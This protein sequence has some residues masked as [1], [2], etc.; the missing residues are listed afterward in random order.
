ML[1]QREQWTKTCIPTTLGIYVFVQWNGVSLVAVF[2]SNMAV[3]KQRVLA[4]VFATVQLV[5]IIC[6]I[7]SYKDALSFTR[8][9]HA[10]I[11]GDN[12]GRH[13]RNT[14]LKPASSVVRTFA[15]LNG[16][17]VNISTS[18]KQTPDSV[19]HLTATDNSAD[20][21]ANYTLYKQVAN[22]SATTSTLPFARGY[23]YRLTNNTANSSVPQFASERDHHSSN[24]SANNSALQI[25]N[26]HSHHAQHVPDIVDSHWPRR[27]LYI[28]C[29][30][31]EFTYTNY[32]S[33]QSAVRSISP[34]A[35]MFA[36]EHYP[37]TQEDK[38]EYNTW[39]EDIIGSF[40][41]FMKYNISES[42]QLCQDDRSG[43]VA[44]IKHFLEKQDF[45]GCLYL[46]DQ[47]VL[48]EPFVLQDA[49]SILD[50]YDKHT[51]QGF[52]YI[53]TEPTAQ[54]QHGKC[55]L[56]KLSN[57]ELPDICFHLEPG[58][59]TGNPEGELDLRRATTLD[60]ES[61]MFNASP[62]ASQLR[63]ITYGS[64]D[65]PEQMPDSANPAPNIAHYAWIG[66]GQMNY[67]FF[68]SVL[69]TIHL[70]KVDK[71]YIHGEDPPKG[72]LWAK[73]LDIEGNH[74]QHVPWDRPYSIFGKEVW[75]IQNQADLIKSYI[76]WNTG[77][78]LMDPDLMFVRPPDP[79]HFHYEA[80]IMGGGHP[81]MLNPSVAISKPKSQYA[82]LWIESEKNFR[83]SKYIWNCCYNMYKVWER[84]PQ[85]AK[86][87]RNFEMICL[88]GE[89]FG[90]W[91]GKDVTVMHKEHLIIPLN[92]TNWK[93]TVVTAHFYDRDP[94]YSFK[95]CAFE[96]E[97]LA[98]ELARMILRASGLLG[99]RKGRVP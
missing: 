10:T 19:E 53:P 60:P 94:F 50:Y 29:G 56:V 32:V 39:L 98:G 34:S 27:I 80:L 42:D 40:P 91:L 28:W 45:L 23:N 18:H 95:Q 59:K 7:S 71:V 86:V 67:T 72:K 55:P 52:L 13:E 38:W 43:S 63:L 41:F 22:V 62:L 8:Y 44:D 96:L 3:R 46:H 92:D 84:K 77:G 68:L 11:N 87:V 51:G 65:Y 33:L 81:H 47:T 64:R 4:F 61:I 78:I 54:I 58:R 90:M 74:I 75:F 35:I 37:D 31:K 12:I 30:K 69:S 66:G 49:D 73:L 88:H 15:T 24:D 1:F 25:M 83:S 5:I 70:G 82:Q 9:N 2:S 20:L 48:K 36:F 97:G 99:H 14:L 76:M 21:A 89:C 93:K 57:D 17:N 26:K 79:E 6:V 16:E 85:I